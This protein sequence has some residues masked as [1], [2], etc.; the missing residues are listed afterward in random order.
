MGI[1]AANPAANALDDRKIRHG[2]SKNDRCGD[3]T[4]TK[5]SRSRKVA[6]VHI[7]RHF[8]AR[9]LALEICGEISNPFHRCANITA[10]APESC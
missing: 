10:K 7:F 4:K 6:V 9:P 8:P 5:K 3:Q 1:T 2:R